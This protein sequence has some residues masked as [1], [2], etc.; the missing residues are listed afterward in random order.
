MQRVASSAAA[1]EHRYLYEVDRIGKSRSGDVSL[2][3]THFPVDAL[4][5]SLVALDVAAAT[6]GGILF[7]TTKSGISCDVNADDDA[8][9]AAADDGRI[10]TGCRVTMP[11]T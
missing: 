3:L 9:P 11:S 2:D 4:G 8:T 7:S 5:R 10:W 1:G 6:G